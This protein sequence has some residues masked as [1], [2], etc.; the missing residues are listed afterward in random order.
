MWPH[1]ESQTWL[2]GLDQLARTDYVVFDHFLPENRMAELLHIFKKFNA[3]GELQAAKI[4]SFDDEK[5]LETIRTDWI[6]WLDRTNDSDLHW[7]FEGID[8]LRLALSRELFITLNGYEFHFA[9]Y[10][11][12]AFYKAHFDQFQHRDNR[13]LSF[14][15]YLNEHWIQGDGGELKIHKPVEHLVEPIFNRLVLF[16]SDTVLHEVL[17]ANRPRKSLTGW[18]LKRPSGV[19]IFGI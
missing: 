2:Q 16:R 14:V 8:G 1:F 7:F 11:E 5:R 4:G 13:T 15:L 12:G 17:P 6:R 18:L 9:L 10:P 3:E 19:G